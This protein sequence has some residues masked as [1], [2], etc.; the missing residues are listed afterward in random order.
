MP[1]LI[2]AHEARTLPQDRP[3]WQVSLKGVKVGAQQSMSNHLQFGSE[4]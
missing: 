4:Q 1:A 2:L 3:P